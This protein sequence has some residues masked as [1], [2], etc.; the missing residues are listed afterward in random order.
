MTTRNASPTPPLNPLDYPPVDRRDIGATLARYVEYHRA[1]NTT[2]PEGPW[3]AYARLRRIYRCADHATRN[4]R[5]AAEHKGTPEGTRAQIRATAFRTDIQQQADALG[6]ILTAEV[7][8]L[9]T[10]LTLRFGSYAIRL[11]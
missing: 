9:T 1:E 8:E 6:V 10:F 4:D 5:F 2:P 11:A 3:I 7:I